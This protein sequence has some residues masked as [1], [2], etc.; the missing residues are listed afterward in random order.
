MYVARPG[1]ASS[2]PDP[3]R[4][5][6]WRRTGGSGMSEGT[7]VRGVTPGSPVSRRRVR[8][9]P[10]VW[11][12]SPRAAP[13]VGLVALLTAVSTALP[14][15]S[16]QEG[17]VQASAMT[18]RVRE[19]LQVRQS[20]LGV[21]IVSLGTSFGTYIEDDHMSSDTA[22]YLGSIDAHNSPPDN[23]HFSPLNTGDSS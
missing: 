17:E 3:D 6:A 16:Q 13:V 10:C 7:P 12:R 19:F 5:E 20:Q 15:V 21:P 1:W 2:V 14:A 18:P 11:R 4:W 22:R 23:D 9:M 8:G